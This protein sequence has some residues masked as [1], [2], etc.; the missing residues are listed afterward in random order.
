MFAKS[1]MKPFKD[2]VKRKG[3]QRSNQEKRDD[4]VM[5]VSNINA[6]YATVALDQHW[7]DRDDT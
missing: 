4:D 3:K 2:G 6:I 1:K 7:T 5:N